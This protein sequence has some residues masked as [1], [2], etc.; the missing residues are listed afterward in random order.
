MSPKILT[1]LIDL[2]D[3]FFQDLLVEGLTFKR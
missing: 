2:L 1:V 3:Q